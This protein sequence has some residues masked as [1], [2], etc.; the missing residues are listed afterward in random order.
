[1]PESDPTRT[2][3]RVPSWRGSNSESTSI[4]TS[5][6]PLS[7]SSIEVTL[8]TGLPPTWTSFPLTSCPAVWK[9]AL[10]LYLSLPDSIRSPTRMAAATIPPTAA[11]RAGVKP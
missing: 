8:P 6:W 1:M 4:S 10:T 11:I 3:A 5:A 7:V 2:V 9:V